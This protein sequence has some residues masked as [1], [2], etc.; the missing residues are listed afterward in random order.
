MYLSLLRKF[1]LAALILLSQNLMAQQPVAQGV[2]MAD[3]LRADGK[4]WVVVAVIAAVFA[5]IIL[6]LVRLDSQIGKLEKEIKN[7]KKEVRPKTQ[8]IDR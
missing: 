7:Q 6:Y 1:P 3:R 5:G 2:E 8:D 4:I